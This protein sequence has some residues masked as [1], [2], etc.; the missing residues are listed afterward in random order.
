MDQ[1]HNGHLPRLRLRRIRPP[2]SCSTASPTRNLARFS[3]LILKQITGQS[4]YLIFIILLFHFL[5][6]QILV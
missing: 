6:K 5:G 2:K 4:I 3:L 1:S